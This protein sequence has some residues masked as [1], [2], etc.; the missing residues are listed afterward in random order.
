MPALRSVVVWGLA[1]EWS[2]TCPAG[3]WPCPCGHP[4]DVVFPGCPLSLRRLRVNS[5][6]TRILSL[7]HLLEAGVS[8][9]SGA[10]TGAGGV[11]ASTAGV[12][13][14]SG[15]GLFQTS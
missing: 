14:G 4:V 6:L 7:H 8:P 1:G 2:L 5:L 10:S 9:V 15:S 13:A 3:L 11:P 12:A